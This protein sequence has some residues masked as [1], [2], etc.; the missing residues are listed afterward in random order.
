MTSKL[1]T[2]KNYEDVNDFSLTEC[3]FNE[4]T[5]QL[6]V[7]GLIKFDSGK[8]KT[9]KFMFNPCGANCLEG[10]NFDICDTKAFTL[11][12]RLSEDKKTLFTESLG[13]HYHI[14]DDLVEGLIRN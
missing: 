13:Y 6:I 14:K 4:E 1:K 10:Y 8:T 2:L 12:S 7:E 9:T 3:Q 11:G 5:N